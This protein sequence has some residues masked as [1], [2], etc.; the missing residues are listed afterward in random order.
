ME[1]PIDSFPT[2]RKCFYSISSFRLSLFTILIF[3]LPNLREHHRRIVKEPIH[4]SCNPFSIAFPYITIP[5]SSPFL[6]Y[7]FA[8]LT[9]R[10]GIR[11]KISKCTIFLIMYSRWSEIVHILQYMRISQVHNDSTPIISW[12]ILSIFSCRTYQ[13]LDKLY[14]IYNIK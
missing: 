10:I 6:S 3:I 12:S 4:I 8:I 7:P 11:S 9:I 14:I 1:S 13:S 2:F 5:D